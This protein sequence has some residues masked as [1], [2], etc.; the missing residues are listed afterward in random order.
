MALKFISIPAVT[1]HTATVIFMHGLG[2]TG[3]GWEPVAKMLRTDAGLGH[4]KWVLPHAR[5]RPVTAN[6]GMTMP[7]WFDIYSFGFDGRE[8]ESGILE[9]RVELS[10]L[11]RAEVDSGIDANRIVVGGFS[12]G[13]AMAL[14]TGLTSEFKLGG[15]VVLSGWLPLRHKLAAMAGPH[16]KSVP[17][18]WGHGEQDPIVG[19]ELGRASTRLVESTMIEFHSYPTLAHSASEEELEELQRWLKSHV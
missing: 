19:I 18:F 6:M 11:I 10:G 1:R 14:L 2:D 4:V 16:A 15:V 7:A 17:I 5:P 12:Q 13:G 3:W 8:D 9:T